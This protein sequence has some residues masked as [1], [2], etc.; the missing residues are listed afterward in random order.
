MI[1]VK[2]IISSLIITLT[3]TGCSSDKPTEQVSNVPKGGFLLPPDQIDHTGARVAFND[4]IQQAS[5]SYGVDE[6]LIKAIIQVESGFDP[7][8]VSRSNAIGLMQIKADAAGRDAYRSQGKQG[9]PSDYELKDPAMNIDLGT[10]YLNILK[11]QQLSGITDPKTLRYA[12]IVSYANGAGALLRTFSDNKQTAFNKINK[13]SPE[14][15][16]QYV[17]R[18]HPAAQ[19]PRYLDKV[20]TAYQVLSP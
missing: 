13:L 6:T 18:R 11:S 19:A 16:Y 14:Q 3:L 12:M 20:I 9:K 7:M 15:F 8:A 2:L 4:Y 1:F 5:R 10:A 17:M